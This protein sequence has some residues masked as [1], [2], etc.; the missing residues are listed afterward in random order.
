MAQYNLHTA[1]SFEQALLS[2]SSLAYQEFEKARGGY[3]GMDIF[4]KARSLKT[5]EEKVK[6]SNA[7]K[8]S[9]RFEKEEES[10]CAI[11]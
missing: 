10:S 8:A 5:E 4:E 3:S 2:N 1:S 11:M 9:N 6:Y 7:I